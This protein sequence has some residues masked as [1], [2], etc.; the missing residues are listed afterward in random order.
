MRRENLLNSQEV[1]IFA[2]HFYVFFNLP[3][4]SPDLQ[5]LFLCLGILQVK[6]YFLVILSYVQV[7]AECSFD[8][9]ILIFTLVKVLSGL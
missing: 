1:N 7:V 4:F 3:E 5:I 8:F 9:F 6:V 2:D